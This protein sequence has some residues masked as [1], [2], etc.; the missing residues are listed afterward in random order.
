M[1]WLR[2]VQVN[3]WDD[4]ITSIDAMAKNTLMNE[5]KKKTDAKADEDDMKIASN[6]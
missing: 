5:K 4:T 2:I 6:R 3:T 1:W